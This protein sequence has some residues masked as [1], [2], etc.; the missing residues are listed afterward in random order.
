MRTYTW[1]LLHFFL[2]VSIAGGEGL[3]SLSTGG[4]DVGL[5][6]GPRV[7]IVTGIAV[8]WHFA[9]DGRGDYHMW[10]GPYIEGQIRLFSSDHLDALIGIRGKLLLVQSNAFIIPGE[11]LGYSIAP[12]VLTTDLRVS[13]QFAV[14]LSVAPFLISQS[15]WFNMKFTRV[16][17]PDDCWVLGLK[18]RFGKI[19]DRQEK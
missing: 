15:P 6:V 18:Y 2:F 10:E 9:I 16:L 11:Y 7:R 5:T 8:N 19:R 4:L 17:Y 1:I 14:F 13:E 12:V 3:L